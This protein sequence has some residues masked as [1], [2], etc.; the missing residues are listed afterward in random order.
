MAN[1]HIK[2]GAPGWLSRLSIH[3]LFSLGDDLMVHEFKP[4]IGLSAVSTEPTSDPLF[5]P[6][7]VP[8][9]LACVQFL[10]FSLS[11]KKEI[12]LKQTNKHKKMFHRAPGWLSW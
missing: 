7:S 12:N 8:P 5:P 2:R 9:P 3:L 4:C 6:L 10:F 1:K 11:L